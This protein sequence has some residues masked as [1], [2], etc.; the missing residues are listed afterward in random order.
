MCL[1]AMSD[2]FS[3]FASL[4]LLSTIPERAS[5][6]K[7]DLACAA[8]RE[9]V[10]TFIYTLLA[11]IRR[12]REALNTVLPTQMSD[13]T[14]QANRVSSGHRGKGPVKDQHRQI[15]EL[16]LREYCAAAIGTM[17]GL[18]RTTSSP[19]RKLKI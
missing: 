1:G 18:L 6:A 10:R 12:L 13:R 14:V 3:S 5:A 17:P 9:R 15:V 7:R 4:R 8:T 2:R 19:D 16:P 11:D